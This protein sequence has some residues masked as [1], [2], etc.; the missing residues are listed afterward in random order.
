VNRSGC[1]PLLRPNFILSPVPR[2]PHPADRPAHPVA[3]N[4]HS[5]WI[6]AYDPAARHPFIACS[7]PAPVAACPDIPRPGRNCLCL[8]PN[9]WRSLR[10]NDL[11]RDRP[12]GRARRGDFLRSCRRCHCRRFP[13]ASGQQNRHQRKY[14]KTCSH[15]SLLA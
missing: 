1:D 7:G 10:H 13:S 14:I 11:S 2:D 9:S 3:F 4:P 6:W 8:D 12:H 5:P 15:V